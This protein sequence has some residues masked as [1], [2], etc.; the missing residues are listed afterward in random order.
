MSTESDE[1]ADEAGTDRIG[2]EPIDGDGVYPFCGLTRFDE[3]VSA[4][5]LPEGVWTDTSSMKYWAQ[6]ETP[7]H[8]FEDEAGVDRDLDPSVLPERGLS[9]MISELPRA[10]EADLAWVHPRTGEVYETLKHNAV[11]NPDRAEQVE[12]GFGNHAEAAAELFDV[13]EGAVAEAIRSRMAS[14]VDD[15]IEKGL[16]DHLSAESVEEVMETVTGD[17]A[18]YHAPTNSYTIINPAAFLRPLC[19]VLEER[20]L[21]DKAFGEVRLSRGGGRASL[22]IFVD[23]NHVEAPSFGDDRPPVVTGLNV[24]WDFYGD[25]SLRACGTGIDW[26]CTNA[27]R[28]LTDREVIKHSGDVDDRIDWHEMWETLLDGVEEKTD[29][30]A[31]IIQ[32]ASETRL[33]FGEL[34]DDIEDHIP[35]RVTDARPWAAL[36]YY[37][38]LPAYLAEHAGRALR[39]DAEDPYGPTWWEI[40]SGATYAITHHTNAEPD[41]GGAIQDQQRT[42]NDLLTNPPGM[43]EEIVRNYEARRDAQESDTAEEGVGTAQIRSAFENTREKKEE[44]ERR[45]EEIGQLVEAANE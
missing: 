9:T 17:D 3:D 36:Y 44:Y 45:Q 23:G 43:E 39:T 41:S 4:M 11:I 27:I 2:T 24:E 20:D 29:Q 40:H 28:R 35:D 12:W 13:D 5:T 38:G 32:M 31:Q 6:N 37:A 42:A 1:P 22:D 15:P 34:P 26:N 25:W 7:A 18:L 21:G 33:D 30:L 19:D 10:A 14:S 8:S 16:S